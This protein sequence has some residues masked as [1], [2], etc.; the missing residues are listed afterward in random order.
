MIV[1]WPAGIEVTG[2]REQISH[3]SCIAPTVLD[4]AGL[5]TKPAVAGA[6]ENFSGI[7]LLPAIQ[8][9][10]STNSMDSVWFLHED[11]KALR[12]GDWKVV[13]AANE[14]WQLYN[15]KTDRMEATNLAKSQPDRVASMVA[16]WDKLTESY[17]QQATNSNL[18]KAGQ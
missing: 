1:H 6:P 12:Q 13:K 17:R 8:T 3:V 5:T 7:S 4:A 15:L 18:E 16:K 2:L 14:E 10:S 9:N 11:N